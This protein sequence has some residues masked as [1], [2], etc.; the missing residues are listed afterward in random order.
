MALT[1]KNPL[2]AMRTRTQ[3][4]QTF[5]AAKGGPQEVAPYQKIDYSKQISD[6]AQARASAEGAIPGQISSQF[7]ALRGQARSIIGAQEQEASRQ[8]K[9]QLDRLSNA[10]GGFGGAEVGLRTKAS[11][12]LAQQMAQTRAQAETGLGAQEA[13][14]KQAFEE[15]KIQRAFGSEQAALDR[16]AQQN[17]I[18]AQYGLQAEQLR[19]AEESWWRELPMNERVTVFNAMVAGKQ[20]GMDSPEQWNRWAEMNKQMWGIQTPL[21]NKE[22]WLRQVGTGSPWQSY[23]E[24]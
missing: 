13:A 17:Q 18:A 14:A 22:D 9:E 2:A 6:A 23:I 12:D 1:F 19:F 24:A 10:G 4:A 3:Q 11:G 16:E 7:A 5:T 15:G 21:M 8:Q 20:A